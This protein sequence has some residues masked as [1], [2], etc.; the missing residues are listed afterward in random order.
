MTMN[1]Y[2]KKLY[3]LYGKKISGKSY[4]MYYDENHPTGITWTRDNTL[5]YHRT[6]L[7]MEC[8][9]YYV[10]AGVAYYEITDKGMNL[11]EM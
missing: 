6:L 11:V 8:I 3:L 4:N 10:S 5:N 1:Q 2:L 9:E 7:Y